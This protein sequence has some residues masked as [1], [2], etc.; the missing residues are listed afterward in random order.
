MIKYL[1]F[2]KT[3][4]ILIAILL[5][6][7]S[8]GGSILLA[9][10]AGS[11]LGMKQFGIL[12]SI[13]SISTLASLILRFGGDK[14]SIRH[15]LEHKYWE[16]KQLVINQLITS[17]VFLC[18]YIAVFYF[19]LLNSLPFQYIYIIP[20]A[21]LLVLGSNLTSI[22]VGTGNTHFAS[23]T[24]IGIM[25]FVLA[26][27][28]WL[29]FAQD[30]NSVDS[31]LIQTF[32]ILIVLIALSIFLQRK[33][34][35]TIIRSKA[36]KIEDSNTNKERLTFFIA[37][38]GGT[39]QTVSLY[40]LLSFII[41]PEQLGEF[42][43]LERIAAII[44]LVTIFQNIIMPKYIFSKGKAKID[45]SA[46]KKIRTAQQISFVFIGLIII[47]GALLFFNYPNK[48]LFSFFYNDQWVLL[49]L[50]HITI[51]SVSAINVVFLF[52]RE[53]VFLMKMQLTLLILSLLLY[54]LSFYWYGMNGLY[55]TFLGL[56]IARGVSLYVKY[57]MIIQRNKTQVRKN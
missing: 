35:Y 40:A 19:L 50:A 49:A 9:L 16:S 51:S 37:G 45:S 6:A 20:I 23:I 24:Q 48:S 27:V 26:S 17:L 13:L 30:K 44:S 39:F 25:Q 15:Y 2:K 11:T 55:I 31:L 7:T 22:S 8:A 10:V 21:S 33:V 53:Q 42:R 1:K 46:I 56:A 54:P 32:L 28:L 52:A 38:L 18:A 57:L 47:A 3:S 34:I 5:R 12:T 14:L 36:K 29:F 4:R 41:T 43:Y